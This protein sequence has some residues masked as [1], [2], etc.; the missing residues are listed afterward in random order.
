MI[1]VI[2]ILLH[3]QENEQQ[4]IGQVALPGGSVGSSVTVSARELGKDQG[5]NEGGDPLHEGP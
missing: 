3:Q 2:R 5:T 1:R 4:I